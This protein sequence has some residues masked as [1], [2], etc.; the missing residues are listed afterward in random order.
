MMVFAPKTRQPLART[1]ACA[2]LSSVASSEATASRSESAAKLKRDGSANG[3]RCRPH[4]VV[5]IEILV[6]ATIGQ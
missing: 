1:S 6:R 3:R 4:D 5:V 2:C